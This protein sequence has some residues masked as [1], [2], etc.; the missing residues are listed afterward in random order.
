MASAIDR[1]Q[2]LVESLLRYNS[3]IDN[4]MQ[5]IELPKAPHSATSI[6]TTEP[7]D[8][9]KDRNYPTAAQ[10]YKTDAFMTDANDVFS[11]DV[12][13]PPL[14]ALTSAT[15]DETSDDDD[16]VIQATKTV[17]KR[18]APLPCGSGRSTLL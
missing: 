1:D 6:P 12:V 13:S 9:A 10:R 17:Q 16:N 5:A 18:V 7:V 14:P 4:N 15:L 2:L 8:E 3:E 11:N